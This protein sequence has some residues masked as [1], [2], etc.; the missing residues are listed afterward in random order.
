MKKR[1][2]LRLAICFRFR[3]L[4][5][6]ATGAERSQRLRIIK[7]GNKNRHADDTSHITELGLS[8]CLPNLVDSRLCKMLPSDRARSIAFL[9]VSQSQ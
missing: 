4:L 7:T 3:I 8:S 1:F 6:I 9:V 2:V 5:A